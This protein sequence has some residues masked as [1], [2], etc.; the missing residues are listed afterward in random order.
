MRLKNIQ[1]TFQLELKHIYAIEEIDSMFYRLID[2]FYKVSRIQLAMNHEMALED[3]ER[4][5]SALNLLKQQKPLKYI[6]GKTEFYGLDFKV[7]EHVL[8]PRPE[9]EELVA[10]VLKQADNENKIRILDVGTGSG[11]IAVSLAKYLPSAH[12]YALDISKEALNIA[13]QN[14]YFNTV[15][16]EFIEADILEIQSIQNLKFDIIVSNPPYIR[17][18]EKTL[19]KPNVLENE[20]HLALFVEDHDALQFYKAIIKFSEYSLNKNGMLFFEINEYLGKEMI[21]LL[22][23]NDFSKLE[24]KQDIFR[25]DRMIK[26]IKN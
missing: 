16:V 12:V 9:T 15:K 26:G 14:A 21:A 5:L 17:K 11:S 25:K 19:M 24:L 3:N 23:A 13:E 4:I 2:A 10:W 20:P 8:I 22:K 7:N 18:Q 1:N 6:I